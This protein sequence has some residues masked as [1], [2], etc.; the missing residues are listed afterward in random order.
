MYRVGIRLLH[1][2]KAGKELLFH[3]RIVGRMPP[4]AALTLCKMGAGA[5]VRLSGD[6]DYSCGNVPVTSGRNVVPHRAWVS[7]LVLVPQ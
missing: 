4:M 7:Q 1:A 2:F 6:R 5:E 3:Q